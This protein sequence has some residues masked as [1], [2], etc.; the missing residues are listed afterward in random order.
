MAWVHM[1][2][3]YVHHKTQPIPAIFCKLQ[4]NVSPMET[5]HPMLNSLTL[6]PFFFLPFV[7]LGLHPRH[8]EVSRLGV[9]SEL[10]LPAYPTATAMPDP[11]PTD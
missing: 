7:F 4:L 5:L 6:S 3:E 9:Q 10:Q 2:Q 1:C 8:M 11:Q